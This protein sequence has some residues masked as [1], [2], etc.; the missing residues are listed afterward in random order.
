MVEDVRRGVLLPFRGA[1]GACRRG[2]P[3][4]LAFSCCGGGRSTYVLAG[5]TYPVSKDGRTDRA[6]TMG[7]EHVGR[8]SW[9][10]RVG[11]LLLD[12]RI[13]KG[14]DRAEIP[15][16]LLYLYIMITARSLAFPWNAK[17][18]SVDGQERSQR[19]SWCARGDK[20]IRSL[21]P[22]VF[23]NLHVNANIDC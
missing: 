12:G 23:L 4:A 14:C 8:W 5:A 18:D 20:L 6:M 22:A 17:A 1:A 3:R 15:Q 9:S 11:G 7:S 10:S 2:D 19:A 16:Q 21:T 13:S